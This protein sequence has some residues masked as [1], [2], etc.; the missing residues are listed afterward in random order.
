MSDDE[1]SLKDGIIHTRSRRTNAGNRLKALLA[2]EEPVEE[3]DADIFAEVPDDEEFDAEKAESADDGQSGGESSGDDSN[4][5]SDA[6]NFSDSESSGIEEEEAAQPEDAGEQELKRQERESAREKRKLERQKMFT[7]KKREPK[8]SQPRKKYHVSVDEVVDTEHR[9]VSQRTSAIRNREHLIERLM[10]QEQRHAAYK[11]PKRK[12]QPQ[13]TQA[14]RLAEAQVTEQKNLASL[15]RFVELEEVRKQQQRLAMLGRRP[16]LTEFIRY[17]SAA[18]LSYPLVDLPKVKQEPKE[19]QTTTEDSKQETEEKVEIAPWKEGTEN[20]NDEEAE[21]GTDIRDVAG[22]PLERTYNFVTA[23]EF[24]GISPHNKAA[25]RQ[26]VM[27][28]MATEVVSP[29]PKRLCP[30]TGLPARFL[31]PS[32]RVAYRSFGANR[33]LKMIRDQE[34]EWYPQLG[35]VFLS[36]RGGVQRAAKG[37]PEG[38]A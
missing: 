9:R 7:I 27:G 20:D 30:F 4:E 37:V 17:T 38:F 5:S 26:L 13:M 8:V 23:H 34:I 10:E 14:Q 2:G 6:S 22:P 11:P 21:G 1:A 3:E 15:N 31:D 18:V 28:P 35:G 29:P 16:K 32:T 12:K 33:V 36:P 19:K 24:P 25:I